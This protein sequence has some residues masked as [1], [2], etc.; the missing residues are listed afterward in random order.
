MQ[1]WR[2]RIAAAS[3]ELARVDDLIVA[4]SG[5]VDSAVLLAIARDALAGRR[6]LAVT[7]VS[8]SMPAVDAR[9]AASVARY[10]A[11]DHRVVR[12]SELENP[13]YRANRGDRCFHCRDVLFSSLGELATREGF[14]AVAY[15]AIADD[16]GDSRPG[17]RAA[18]RHRILA[19]LLDA[20]F[21]KED[22]RRAADAEG[23][24]VAEKP[25]AACLASRI[26]VGTEVNPA[27]LRQVARAE[28]ALRGLGF[29]QLRV[30]HHGEIA[31]IELDAAGF[32][33]LVD[34]GL[35]QR[36]SEVV[37]AAGFRYVA[38]DLDGYRPGSLNPVAIEPLPATPKRDG[39]Q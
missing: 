21:S 4:L 30:R 13:D 28:E 12:T 32:R 25:A 20:G 29:G 23:L 11:V 7:A 34:H 10:L 2:R 6:L 9:D 16:L 5:G 15:G 17:M 39:G 26:P 24:P 27:R 18:L 14:G 36:V 38:L 1:I 22:V 31:R 33:R 8:A 19:P 35:G 3:G 37:R